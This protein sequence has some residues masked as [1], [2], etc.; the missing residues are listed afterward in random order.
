MCNDVQLPLLEFPPWNPTLRSWFWYLRMDNARKSIFVSWLLFILW[1][2]WLFSIPL[3]FLIL[4]QQIPRTQIRFVSNV[5]FVASDFQ[6]TRLPVPGS[7]LSQLGPEIF[8]LLW[9]GFQR[10]K[11]R[12][13][14][15]PL[16]DQWLARYVGRKNEQALASV[17]GKQR[18]NGD[19]TVIK[20]AY[21]ISYNQ[22]WSICVWPPWVYRNYMGKYWNY[23]HICCTYHVICHP[24]A[25]C[26]TSLWYRWPIEF[27]NNVGHDQ[28]S[29]WISLSQWIANS[30]IWIYIYII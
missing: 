4:T 6:P 21:D 23:K 22:W 25:I 13:W 20:L 15:Q 30:S 26:F 1:F 29:L 14:L 28:R 24:L 9:R 8:R 27:A 18:T 7:Q 12:S 19:F 10:R 5:R 17:I 16:S 2:S 3:I 11:H